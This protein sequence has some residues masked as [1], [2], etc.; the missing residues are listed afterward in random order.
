MYLFLPI[1]NKG[2]SYLTKSELRAIVVCTIGIFILWKDLM[3]PKVDVFN[4]NSG[5]SIIWLLTYYLTGA[6]IGKYRVNYSGMKKNIYSIICI[7]IYISST[8]LYIKT[9]NNLQLDSRNKKYHEAL[10]SILSRILTKRFDSFLKIAQSITTCLLFL[11]I[12]YNSVLSKIIC[13][14]GPLSFAVYLIHDHPLVRGNVIIHIFENDKNYYSLNLTLFHILLKSLK[15]FIF[16]II[17]DYFRN[18]IFILFRVRKMCIIFA[19][20]ITKLFN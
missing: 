9:H 6:Y 19:E 14:I 5:K 16:C 4:L 18:L 10:V 13:S 17:I 12:E 1:I 20:S 3:N 11:Q 7:L 2:I 8:F 15:M